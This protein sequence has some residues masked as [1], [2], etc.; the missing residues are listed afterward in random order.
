ML[1]QKNT[2]KNDL[3]AVALQAAEHTARIILKE[4][5]GKTRREPEKLLS[6]EEACEFFSCS[7]P[8]LKRLYKNG[9][10]K[11][12]KLPNGGKRHYFKRSELVSILVEGH[13]PQ[14]AV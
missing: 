9:Y 3:E 11:V 7:K 14:K 10:M 2:P 4:I 5:Q 13:F 8:T 6:L 12:Y 1:P